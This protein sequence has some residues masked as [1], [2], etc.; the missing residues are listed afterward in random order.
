MAKY[1]VGMLQESP[2]FFS[3]SKKLIYIK[4]S[5]FFNRKYDFGTYC[6]YTKYN[7]CLCHFFDPFFTLEIIRFFW[8][9]VIYNVFGGVP[10]NVQPFPYRKEI[11]QF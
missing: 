6:F 5:A 8:Y 3:L 2:S 7:H 11:E 4:F 1:Y 9:I 10:W